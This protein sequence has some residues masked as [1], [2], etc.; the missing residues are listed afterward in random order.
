[1]QKE[2]IK[3]PN[4]K[5]EISRHYYPDSLIGQINGIDPS[6]RSDQDL[7]MDITRENGV[8]S[9]SCGL[10]YVDSPYAIYGHR[11]HRTG[12]PEPMFK[13][14]SPDI[15]VRRDNPE[16]FDD[17][18]S[19]IWANCE[20]CAF[21]SPLSSIATKGKS[22]DCWVKPFEQAH[23]SFENAKRMI[24]D[25]TVHFNLQHPELGGNDPV[26]VTLMPSLEGVKIW[27]ANLEHARH[28]DALLKSKSLVFSEEIMQT[29]SHFYEMSPSMEQLLLKNNQVL[30]E[31]V[32]GSVIDSEYR[33][34][35]GGSQGLLRIVDPETLLPKGTRYSLT[36]G[37]FSRHCISTGLT[38]LRLPVI[39]S[40]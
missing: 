4:S 15:Y 29:Y 35:P 10:V 40:N 24:V 18:S 3:Y 13:F 31:F 14:L 36:N 39:P 7:H 5:L 22:H 11:N 20:L 23:C 28:I 37:Y 12:L 1:M 26:H 2:I 25:Q 8:E 38:V 30:T 16:I 32:S 9:C 21:S 27:T 6:I 19:E 33:L 34:S 17:F